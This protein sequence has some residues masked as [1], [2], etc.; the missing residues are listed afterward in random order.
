MSYSQRYYIWML[1][2]RKRFKNRGSFCSC[3]WCSFPWV[4]GERPKVEASL[5]LA[6][7]CALSQE[8]FKGWC[9][10]HTPTR[11]Y[12]EVSVSL[13]VLASSPVP[14]VQGD[15]LLDG[16]SGDWCLAAGC[17]NFIYDPEQTISHL[18]VSV[19]SSVKWADQTLWTTLS[20]SRPGSVQ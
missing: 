15:R 7:T 14:S 17:A 3:L 4:F 12:A 6:C 20:F 2:D 1:G 9:R 8:W 5:Y 16:D 18:Y 19:F 10:G 13:G 11:G